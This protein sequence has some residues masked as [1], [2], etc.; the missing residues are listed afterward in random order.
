MKIE[1]LIVQY[2]YTNKKVTLQDIG[3]FYLAENVTIP[4]EHDKDAALPDNAITFEYNMKSVQ[5][6]GLIA[7]I[8]QQTRKI[9]PLATSD[10]ESFTI[11]GR[12]FM[13]IGKPLP[14]EGLGILQKN[15]HGEYEFIQGHS[16]NPRLEPVPAA[17][18]EKNKEDIVFTTPPREKNSKTGMVAVII[19]FLILAAGTAFY[20]FSK[21]NKDQKIDQLIPQK[22]ADTVVTKKET[23]I[24]QPVVTND[25]LKLTTGLLTEGSPFKIIIREYNTASKASDITKKYRSLGHN[26]IG[27][28]DDSINYKIAV[29]F[30]K[31][32]LSDSTALKDSLSRIFTGSTP[33]LEKY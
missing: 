13:N 10:L 14:I 9:K 18:R 17:L 16:I 23:V 15:Q 6:D 22:P 21:N 7:F 28:S 29:P 20:F 3:V 24:Q 1:Q 2:L 19:I 26:V 27:Y 12:Q 25:N 30:T 4:V 5:D 32:P 31:R 11:L 33:Y 8:V